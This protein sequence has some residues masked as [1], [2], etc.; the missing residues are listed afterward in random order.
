METATISLQLF[1]GRRQPLAD[2]SQLLLTARDGR[3]QTVFRDFVDKPVITLN[4]LPFR[5]NPIAD[6]YTL[7]VSK[8]DH[9]DA[10]FTPVRVSPKAPNALKLMLLPRTP[11]F[12]FD[13]FDRLAPTVQALFGGGVAEAGRDAYD[14]L[15]G[16]AM[17]TPALACAL[18]LTTA[19]GQMTL[20][21]A[22]GLT[23][24]PLDSL[25][26]IEGDIHQDRMFVWADARLCAQV[27]STI[28]RK[29]A[30]GVSR[31]VKAPDGLHEG[32]TFSAKQTDFGEANIQFSF[33]EK[34]LR[35][36]G[37]KDVECMLVDLDIDY[38][39]D[40]G[41][42]LLLEVFPN[43]L[44]ERIFGKGSSKSLTDPS[45]V[46]GLRWTAA[47]RRGRE[48]TPPYVIEFA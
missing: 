35:P 34:R 19:L 39:N 33:H 29:G 11:L 6:G 38:F 4:G 20:A 31:M 16:T 46:Y 12:V 47:R 9:V 3:Q 42:H 26:A 41:A 28:D 30:G 15:R 22:E 48:F 17:S 1:D 23:S 21:P 8:K 24:N 43:T 36:I 5:D 27:R 44:K 32:A 7:L 25:V 2:A 45:R 10:G 13:D 37:P 40:T 14:A 18:N